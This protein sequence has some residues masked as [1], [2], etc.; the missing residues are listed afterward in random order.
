MVLFP[1]RGPEGRMAEVTPMRRSGRTFLVALLVLLAGC[2]GRP[3]G[4]EP[5]SPFDINR[6]RGVW[7]EIMRLDHSFE[8]G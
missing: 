8:R 6:Y 2:T 4:F 1:G 5:V 7:F 3:D